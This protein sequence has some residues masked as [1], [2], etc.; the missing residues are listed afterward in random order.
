MTIFLTRHA[1]AGKR[2]EWTADDHLRP[3]SKRGKAQA[4]GL[5]KVVG[6]LV[7]GRIISSPY[8]R[9]MQTM[10]PLAEKFELTVQSSEAFAEGAETDEAYQILLELDEFD[11]VACSHG[12]LIPHLLRRLVAD[13]METDGPLID[14]KGSTWVIELRN[15]RPFLG[16]Y[17]PP[18]A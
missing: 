17:V 6:N 1:H 8:V 16:R 11:G 13:G 4:D 10:E 15:G 7:I 5:T 14:Q 2:S 3:L 12:D 18:S 9:C